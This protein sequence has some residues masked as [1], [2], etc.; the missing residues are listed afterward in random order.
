MVDVN[1][2]RVV[3]VGVTRT[4]T[5]E[6]TAQRLREVTPFG[7]GP[8]GTNFSPALIAVS[9][10]EALVAAEVDTIVNLFTID[11][12]TLS[13]GR[14]LMTDPYWGGDTDIRALLQRQT[15]FRWQDERWVW[16]TEARRNVL[17]VIHVLKV[18]DGC[19]YV[20]AT[21]PAG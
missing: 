11:G 14:A 15:G 8:R 1:S 10:T 21:R 20:T 9:P 5:E 18:S 17:A 3:F 6:W 12:S 13:S 7:N 2:K 16:F 19:E 4:P